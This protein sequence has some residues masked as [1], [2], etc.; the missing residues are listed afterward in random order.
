MLSLG[1]MKDGIIVP[2][3]EDRKRIITQMKV[4]TTLKGDKSWIQQKSDSEEE[5]NH[6]PLHSPLRTRCTN[7]KFSASPRT[8]SPARRCLS[9]R[10]AFAEP[11]SQAEPQSPKSSPKK[12]HSTT[13]P[14]GYLI[15]G[16]FTK[17]IDKTP[18]SN[19]SSSGS[20]K[21]AKSASLP[22][23]TQGYKMTTEEYKRLAPYNIKRELSDPGDVEPSVSPDEQKKRTEA[24]SSVLR[25]TASRERSYVI[26][27]AKKS[28]GVDIEDDTGPRS[29]SQTVPASAWFSSRGKS[30]S[31]GEGRSA[32]GSPCSQPSMVNAAYT[33]SME[34]SGNSRNPFSRSHS[35]SLFKQF[36]SLESS[37]KTDQEKYQMTSWDNSTPKAPTSPSKRSEKNER[38]SQA[39]LN[40][41]TPS[42]II[43]EDSWEARKLKSTT[44]YQTPPV[45]HIVIS[46][47]A[48]PK[49]SSCHY[50]TRDADST[51]ETY[52]RSITREHLSDVDVGSPRSAPDDKVGSSIGEVKYGSPSSRVT[53]FSEHQPVAAKACS[54]TRDSTDT[55]S[56]ARYNVPTHFDNDKGVDSKRSLSDFER[57][58]TQE[59]AYE[60]LSDTEYRKVEAHLA[61]SGSRSSESSLNT[62]G[63]QSEFLRAAKRD[64]SELDNAR[65]SSLSTESGVATLESHQGEH[66]SDSSA[67]GLSRGVAMG[68]SEARH[69]TYVDNPCVLESG[70]RTS[71]N[72]NR[73]PNNTV[74]SETSYRMP[75]YLSNQPYN[76]RKLEIS[77]GITS[78]LNNQAFNMQSM[79]YYP[80]RDGSV[81]SSPRSHRMPFYN[82]ICDRQIRRN[83]TGSKERGA[84]ASRLK[85]PSASG[86]DSDPT[87]SSKGLLFVKESIN[88][89]ELS[90]SPRYNSRSLADL[91]E[92][93]RTSY[94]SAS[95]LNSIPPK[96]PSGDICTYCGREIRNCAKITIENLKICCHEYCFRCGICHKPMGDRLHEIFIHRDI[97]HCDKCYEKL[98]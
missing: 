27:A 82:D 60:S 46:P 17:T 1:V 81:T 91:S 4:R 57:K 67:S 64:G 76:A 62:S 66:G 83:L 93:E 71:S 92:L 44:V 53:E 49:R 34:D 10:T 37:N 54:F 32:S 59:M 98:F 51:T 78:H 33:T 96:R 7:G 74:R 43:S 63:T 80:F 56:G 9:P 24:A 39:T 41:E 97:V 69:R 12:S 20:Q 8:L 72:L 25:R 30:T 73:Q 47:E 77:H 86:Y 79:A 3:E 88:S 52:D 5:Q 40:A 18:P 55:L 84:A 19:T 13:S 48:S 23:F 22:R 28:N 29:R 16:V 75:S 21:S 94:G 31:N 68:M 38:K 90:S 6:S 45:P 50:R 15:R 89:T 36:S 70:H 61:K 26:S 11:T 42:T 87:M 2:S 85:N 14:S 65:S 58:A 95:F 35:E